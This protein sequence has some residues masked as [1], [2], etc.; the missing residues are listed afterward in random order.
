MSSEQSEPKEQEATPELDNPFYEQ[1]LAEYDGEERDSGV[2]AIVNA[3]S[4]DEEA[5]KRLYVK[6][7]AD[8]LLKGYNLLALV[9]R[10]IWFSV[11]GVVVLVG[12]AALIGGAFKG[13]TNIL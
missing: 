3:E 1:A 4:N 11:F 13:D 8:A 12:V 9:N 10:I 6:V 2:W 7:R 5:S